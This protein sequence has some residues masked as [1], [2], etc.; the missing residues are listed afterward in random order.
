MIEENARVSVN[1]GKQHVLL[2]SV[3]TI[4]FVSASILFSCGGEKSVEGE[5]IQSE[6]FV[7]VEI[8]EIRPQSV[9]FSLSATGDIRP[10]QEVIVST[11]ISGTVQSLEVEVGDRVNANE[12]LIKLDRELKE[13]AVRQAEAQLIMTKASCEKAEKD[14]ARREQLAKTN[15]I[16]ESEYDAAVL[17]AE[18]TRGEMEM[19]E[20]ALQTAR[21]QLRDTEVKSPIPGVVAQRYI[22]LGTAVMPGDRIA[23]V[24][25]LSRVKISVG[26]AETGIGDIRA[27]QKVSVIADGAPG[28]RF[29]GTIY[30]MAPEADVS[31]RTFPVE[32]LVPND[33]RMSLRAGM[34]AQV[35]IITATIDDALMVPQDALL[36]E[37]AERFVYRIEAGSA[38]RADVRTGRS[39]GNNVLITDGLNP[40]DRIVVVGHRQLS[41][42]VKIKIV[43]PQ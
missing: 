31:T 33:S 26:I 14:R 17:Q 39:Q 9:S 21:K 11:E 1:M 43:S 23:K 28:E 12:I 19:A 32:I 18:V 34:A 37:G 15:D 6:R 29:D 13:L 3:V 8:M 5:R 20:A 38:H 10:F 36:G 27:G 25:D 42:G 4:F 40:G 30:T 16:A 35:R 7:P 22:E 41:D 2:S 24:I